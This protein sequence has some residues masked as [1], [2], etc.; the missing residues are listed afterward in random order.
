MTHAECEESSECRAD[1]SPGIA[2]NNL[3]S[4]PLIAH[5]LPVGSIQLS[6]QCDGEYE[7]DVLSKVELRTTSDIERVLG[8]LSGVCCVA[9]VAV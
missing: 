4:T 5:I 1:V 2:I 8:S 3:E 6:K 9:H 7:R